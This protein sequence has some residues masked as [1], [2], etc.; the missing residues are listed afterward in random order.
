MSQKER[1]DPVVPIDNGCYGTIKSCIYSA[2]STVPLL[3]SSMKGISNILEVIAEF[4]EFVDRLLPAYG[5]L[6]RPT[7]QEF[8]C[9]R[10]Y[11]R[12][13]VV[14]AG[15]LNT[16][17]LAAYWSGRILPAS[18]LGSLNSVPRARDSR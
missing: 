4:D 12:I 11:D 13:L 16:Q 1:T 17:G 18:N 10:N 2:R 3:I 15:D 5:F 7:I 14:A 6:S 9:R 8:S